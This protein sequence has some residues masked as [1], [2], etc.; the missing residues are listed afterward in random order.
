MVS[1]SRSFA[2]TRKQEDKGKQML[3]L[4]QSIAIQ[5][6]SSSVIMDQPCAAPLPQSEVESNPDRK[7]FEYLENTE[8]RSKDDVR[9]RGRS[10]LTQRTPAKTFDVSCSSFLSARG[11]RSKKACFRSLL[12]KLRKHVGSIFRRLLLITVCRFPSRIRVDLS[13]MHTQH[14][15]LKF[16]NHE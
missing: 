5:S 12:V 9:K 7:A 6:H 16:L 8:V 14:R 10:P 2:N 4:A 1:S 13:T 15:S 3:E 11:A